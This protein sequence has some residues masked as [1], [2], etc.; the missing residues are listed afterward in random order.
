M[1]RAYTEYELQYLRDFYPNTDTKE[2]AKK[3]KRSKAAINTK[4]SK[5]GIKKSR[6][7]ILQLEN[8]KSTRFKKGLIPFNKG[9]KREEFLSEQAIIK[10]R[11]TQFKKGHVPHNHKP[12]GH[13]RV[14]K[15]GYI[16]IKVKEPNVFK[17]KHRL[18]YENHH[19]KI[20]K[21]YN[22]IF[23]DG[24]NRN[25]NINNLKCISNAELMAKNTIHQY[26]K[27]LKDLIII[28]NK[29]KRQINE[30]DKYRRTKKASI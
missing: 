21:G 13:E 26:P 29:L 22:V 12:I 6:E 27:D 2:M 16:E 10:I 30:T 8:G 4:A 25:F 1:A 9:K 5:M 3:L 14:D 11:K 28:N 18:I 20:P 15:N 17:S 19:G 7:F 23:I 24:N